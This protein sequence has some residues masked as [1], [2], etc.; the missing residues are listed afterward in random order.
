MSGH[1]TAENIDLISKSISNASTQSPPPSAGIAPSGKTGTLFGAKSGTAGAGKSGST[2]TSIF[3]FFQ[4]NVGVA[5]TASSQGSS[6]G[7]IF[8]GAT[9]KS[10]GV[11]SATTKT[12][13]T[14][15]GAAF[16]GWGGEA[17]SHCR[18][19]CWSTAAG[20]SGLM[21]SPRVPCWREALYHPWLRGWS[22]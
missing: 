9:G 2:K 22:I 16:S 1:E 5:P 4:S 3:S 15:T 11:G 8:A 20:G 10:G 21:L 12:A 14:K 19:G 18:G 13:V 6:G 17:V 7:K